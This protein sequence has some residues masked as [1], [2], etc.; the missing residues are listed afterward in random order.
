MSL[1]GFDAVGRFAIGQ[2]PRLSVT[3]I[4]TGA[5]GSFSLNGVSALFSIRELVSVGSYI[6]TGNAASPKVGFGAS[7]G[8]FTETGVNALFSIVFAMDT[9]TYAI[10]G[11]AATFSRDFNRW[12]A[13][14]FDT[15]T[16]F[17]V[18]SGAETW[19]GAT[20]QP[21][22]WT[23]SAQ[24]IRVFSPYVFALAPV[25]DTGSAGGIWSDRPIQS[26]VWTAV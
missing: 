12:I 17:S 19:S 6:V 14:P 10:T 26:E 16:W 9:Q 15:D 4:L 8:A 5:T 18:T 20:G 23:E 21:E 1:L 25:F 7:P 2:L 13:Q 24:Q 11:N 3:Y 22:A